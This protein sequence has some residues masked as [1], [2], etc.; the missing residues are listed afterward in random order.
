MERST[1]NSPS[2]PP[3]AETTAAVPV[4]SKA[5][6]SGRKMNSFFKKIRL[7]IRWAGT[8]V[9]S[10]I[11]W[12]G[13]G[14]VILLVGTGFS[15][16][17][18]PLISSKSVEEKLLLEVRQKKVLEF[19][20][21]NREFN[22]KLNA[23]GTSLGTFSKLML[24][25]ELNPDEFRKQQM[26]FHK[27]YSD[28]YIALDEIAWWWYGDLEREAIVL[29]LS[30]PQQLGH[31]HTEIREYG[32]SVGISMNALH[33]LAHF[34]STGPFKADE[35][36][37]KKMERLSGDMKAEIDRQRE[38]R[39]ELVARISAILTGIERPYLG[40]MNVQV[41]NDAGTGSIKYSI[42]VKNFGSA[43]ATILEVKHK[44]SRVRITRDEHGGNYYSNDDDQFSPVNGDATSLN[45]QGSFTLDGFSVTQ[46]DYSDA[47]C[48]SMFLQ[49][50]LEIRYEH[51][52]REYFYQTTWRYDPETK[53]FFV[54]EGQDI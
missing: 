43:E 16:W 8:R 22:S 33:P 24:A 48:R 51:S 13:P 5:D 41:E 15:L 17:L 37:R 39:R 52:S 44:I 45:S 36:S 4:H 32:R 23:L 42:H 11:L 10:G 20:E 25:L 40:L 1:E 3:P 27:E 18:I 29:R 35:A 54:V 49:V 21:R 26:L 46:K 7:A 31:L 38:I 28:R 19:G 53:R 34:L 2:P 47:I 30:T 50:T 9:I 6:S 14:F 12:L